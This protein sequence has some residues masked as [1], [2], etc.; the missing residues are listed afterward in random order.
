MQTWA[1]WQRCDA[2][3]FAKKKKNE[4]RE[5]KALIHTGK[6]NSN[7]NKKLSFSNRYDRPVGSTPWTQPLTIF[8]SNYLWLKIPCPKLMISCLMWPKWTF[9]FQKFPV[10]KCHC[11][12]APGANANANIALLLPENRQILTRELDFKSYLSLP[13]TTKSSQWWRHCNAIPDWL[14]RQWKS[15]MFE[16][17]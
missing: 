6:N 16:C 17:V 15:V 11:M 7:V 12:I 9:Y 10:T 2:I 4:W 5:S 1:L 14:T 3:S 8:F 13:S